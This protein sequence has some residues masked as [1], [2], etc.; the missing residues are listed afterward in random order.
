MRIPLN[1]PGMTSL[2]KAGLA[3]LYMTLE[4]LTRDQRL[5]SGLEWHLEPTSVTFDWKEERLKE[6]FR[7]L[8]SASFWLDQGFIRLTGLEIS[9]QPKPDQ[10]HHLY[11][12]L[13]H[14]FLQFGPHRPTDSKRTLTYEVDERTY[15]IK[16]FAP[17]KSFRHQK[18]E[19]DFVD[20]NGKFKMDVETS[21]WLYPGGSQRHVVHAATKVTERVEKALAL[22]YAPVGVFYYAIRSRY[23]GRKARLAMIVPEVSDLQTYSEIRQAFA[24]QGVLELT[25][26]SASDAALRMLVSIEANKAVNELTNYLGESFM[27]RVVTFG[28]VSWNEKQ[29]TRTYTRSIHGGSLPGLDDYRKASAIFKNRWQKVDAK[30]D[31]KGKIIEPERYFVKTYSARELIAENVAQK[32]PWY[33]DLT[34]FMSQKETRNQLLFEREELHQMVEKAFLDDSERIFIRV[35]HESWRRRMGKLGERAT[36]EGANFQSLVR[37]ESERLRTSLARSKNAETLRETVVDFWARAGTNQE[38]QREGL[39]KLLPLFNENNWRKARDLALLALISY[40][41]QSDEEK[42][43]LSEAPQ[44]E[45]EETDE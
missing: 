31:R 12:A 27:C 41:P 5:I 13:L 33:Q 8:I 35:C 4:A 17:V 30:M 20:T 22:L 42:E 43:A 9:G 23:R 14:S 1:A 38:L 39:A 32:K 44:V 45:E 40:Q 34:T 21:S 3:G 37:R 29:K 25:A 11:N 15:S 26:S 24:Q 6:A 16:D 10:K 18:A 19:K 7:D 28:I 2:H 36:K